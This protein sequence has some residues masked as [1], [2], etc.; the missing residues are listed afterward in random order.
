VTRL[1]PGFIYCARCG[2][3]KGKHSAIGGR[4]PIG[5]AFSLVDRF[6]LPRNH[7]ELARKL[8]EYYA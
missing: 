5:D 1:H 8:R 6:R 3:S 7:K 2:Q 4:C